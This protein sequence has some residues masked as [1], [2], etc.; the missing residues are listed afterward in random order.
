MSRAAAVDA[1]ALVETHVEPGA[2]IELVAPRN[3]YTFRVL[4]KLSTLLYP[5]VFTFVELADGWEP[6]GADGA[7]P[8]FVLVFPAG[9]AS[10]ESAAEERLQTVAEGEW[11]RL[12]RWSDPPR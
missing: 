3:L 6:A 11:A 4:T 5:R 1:Y 10:V 7:R 8:A 9:A 12:L 2:G